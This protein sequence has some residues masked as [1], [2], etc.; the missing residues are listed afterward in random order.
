MSA[1]FA[2]AKIDEDHI[3]DLVRKAIGGEAAFRKGALGTL[4]AT[5]IP[6]KTPPPAK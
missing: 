2:Q 6:G 4:V 5:K 1:A 3:G